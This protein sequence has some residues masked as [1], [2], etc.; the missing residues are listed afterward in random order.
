MSTQYFVDSNG[1]FLGGFSDA[2]PPEN[3]I[4]VPSPPDDGRQKWDGAQWLPLEAE[5]IT[6]EQTIKLFTAAV[7]SYMDAS[8]QQRN[9]DGILSLCTYAT[10]TVAKFAAE[11]Q[12]GVDF[13]DTC[14]SHCY[15]VLADV[16]AGTREQ[17]AMDDFMAELPALAWPA[18]PTPTPTPT[19]RNDSEETSDGTTDET[20]L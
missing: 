3:S 17:P 13:R 4:E 18:D 5:P 16:E 10:S 7:Q 12:A 1:R 6:P 9:Y 8:A 15:Q 20:V 19:P 14:W 2:E 11:G